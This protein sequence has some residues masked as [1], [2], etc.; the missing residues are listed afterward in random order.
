MYVHSYVNFTFVGSGAIEEFPR[1]KRGDT[2]SNIC[3]GSVYQE[4]VG[5]CQTHQ[6]Y[7]FNIGGVPVFKSSSFSFWPLHLLINELPPRKRYFI[8]TLQGLSIYFTTLF[9]GLC[10]LFAGNWYGSC[11][12]D[13]SLFL[14]P[15]AEILTKIRKVKA[16]VFVLVTTRGM[17]CVLLGAH[18]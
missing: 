4:L 9:T 2:L 5:F 13:M 14:W 16:H 3:D 15:L 7:H 8:R 11:K 10:W 18:I 17:R 6:T 12:P 1:I